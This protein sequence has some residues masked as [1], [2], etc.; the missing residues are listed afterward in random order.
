[1]RIRRDDWQ[2]PG[3]PRIAHWARKEVANELGRCMGLISPE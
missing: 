1:M 3:R 2:D